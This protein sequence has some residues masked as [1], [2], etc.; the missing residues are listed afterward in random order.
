MFSAMPTYL[1]NV[2]QVS[3]AALGH[4][5]GGLELV[6]Y[7]LRVFSGVVSDIFRKRKVL[8]V[9]ALF[10]IASS[11]PLLAFFPILGVVIFARILDRLGN[12]LQASPREALISDYTNKVTKGAA[13]GLRNSLGMAG[14]MGGAALLWWLMHATNNDY[15]IVFTVAIF[16]PLVALLLL[17]FF[18]FDKPFAPKPKD[19]SRAQKT[20]KAGSKAAKASEVNESSHFS[21]REI[22]N[23]PRVYWLIL[24]VGAFYC[25]ANP[26]G[27]FL[28]LHAQAK[29]LPECDAATIMMMQNILAALIS[30][31][32]GRLSDRINRIHMLILCSI[33]MIIANVFMI[34]A[35]SIFDVYVGVA[36][37]G[38]QFGLNQSLLFA[39]IASIVPKGLRGT[40]FGVFYLVAA[41]FL[42]TSNATAGYVLEHYTSAHIFYVTGFWACMGLGLLIYMKR[43]KMRS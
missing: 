4:I 11:R 31:P 33:L 5:E 10:F 42:Y 17:V 25:L 36:F 7:L 23:M 2:L 6:A 15:G 16:P 32:I 39:E 34:S 30:Y 18:V 26:A 12:G 24:G 1:V 22:G 40:G 38:L 21:L 13:Y 20:P 28:V 3:P 8:L 29:G 35:N 43:A 14:S 37:W 9:I 41:A 19:T 27:A